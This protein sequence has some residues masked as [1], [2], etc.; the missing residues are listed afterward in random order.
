[1]DIQNLSLLIRDSYGSNDNYNDNDNNISTSINKK[2]EEDECIDFHNNSDFVILDDIKNFKNKTLKNYHE[3][4]HIFLFNTCNYIEDILNSYSY[5]VN[6]ILEQANVDYCRTKI[7]L[8]K[9]RVNTINEFICR[10][11]HFNNLV[12]ASNIKDFNFLTILIILP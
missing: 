11:D 10:N 12:L 2:E 8:N 7:N 9:M 4:N 1:M 5:D 6:K 3:S